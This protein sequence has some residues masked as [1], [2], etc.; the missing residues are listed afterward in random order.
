[1]EDLVDGVCC[2]VTVIVVLEF[3]GEGGGFLIII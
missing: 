1:M 3:S 2:I